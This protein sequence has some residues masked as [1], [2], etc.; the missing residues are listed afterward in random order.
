[1]LQKVNEI[2]SIARKIAEYTRMVRV[3]NKVDAF[4]PYN[5]N[6]TVMAHCARASA[7]RGSTPLAGRQILKILC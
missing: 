1:M 4:L 7:V 6:S 5:P 3:K 2:C